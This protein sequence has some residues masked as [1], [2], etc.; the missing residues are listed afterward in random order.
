MTQASRFT[1]WLGGR[2]VYSTQA[3]NGKYWPNGTFASSFYFPFCL[4]RPRPGARKV[5]ER[6][7]RTRDEQDVKEPQ[8]CLRTKDL[9]LCPE[10][11]LSNIVALLSGREK[12]WG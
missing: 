10:L 6:K 7:G 3:R 12:R 1:V 5:L 9:S 2:G 4:R 8:T 11:G